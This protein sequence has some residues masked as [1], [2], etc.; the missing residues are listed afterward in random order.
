[1]FNFCQN[2]IKGNNLYYISRESNAIIRSEMKQGYATAKTLPG[3]RSY[4]NFIPISNTKIGAKVVSEQLEY[5][6]VFNFQTDEIIKECLSNINIGVF[7]CLIYDNNPWIGLIE[8]IDVENK[9]FQV[10]FMHPCYPSRS[11]YWPSRDD[12]CWVPPKNLFLMINIPST[13]TGRH[14][15]ITEIDHQS[16]AGCWAKF[17]PEN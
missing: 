1:M 9:D 15:K 8:E 16:I 4:H 12:V 2:E 6:F 3:T 10:R 17:K 13:V 14:Y 5:S 11:Y 7:I